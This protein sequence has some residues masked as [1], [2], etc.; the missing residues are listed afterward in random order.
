MKICQDGFTRKSKEGKNMKRRIL[1]L[2]I[3]LLTLTSCTVPTAATS[4]PTETLLPASSPTLNIGPTNTVEATSTVVSATNVTA[5]PVWTALPTISTTA[6]LQALY[7]WLEGKDECLLPCWAGITPG[8]TPW[9]EAKYLIEP[10][11]GFTKLSFF[12]NES[13]DFGECSEISWSLPSPG[14]GHGY[15]YSKLPENTIHAIIVE[16]TDPRLVEGLSLQNVFSKYGKPS[17]LLLSTEPDQP[18]QK[19]LE[20]I[21]VYPERQFLIKYSKYA[22][23]KDNN[24]ESCGTDSYIKLVVLDNPDQLMSLEAI[25]N[26]VE[27]KDF[28]VDIW[29]KSVEEATSMTI[30]SFYDTFREANAPCISTP[31]NVWQP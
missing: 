12:Q 30:D 17:L 20:L 10:I 7:S 2:A 6:G 19:F 1:V 28:H 9:D 3:F 16:I 27:T 11:T 5:S 13:C 21:L 18:G 4:K 29:H 22:D 25:A 31:I 24:I 14:D 8:Q 15:I 26:S 23:L